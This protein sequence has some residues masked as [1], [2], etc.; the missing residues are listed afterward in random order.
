M[1]LSL[2][3]LLAIADKVDP[4]PQL[5]RQPD[6]TCLTVIGHG[7]E[8]GCYLTTSDGVLIVMDE[9][10]AYVA[11]VTDGSQLLSSG[12]LAHEAGCRDFSEKMAVSLQNY[13]AFV[14]TH[15][16]EVHAMREKRDAY[17][18]YFPHK[19]SPKVL[20]VLVEYQDS[21][22]H[23]D[24]SREI[25]D[26][27]LNADTLPLD[28]ADGTLA[29]NYSSVRQ[30]FREMSFGQFTPQF[31]VVG[32]VRL[33]NT[34]RY[35]GAGQND[36][37]T[38]LVNDAM[39]QVL[40]SIDVTEYD[41]DGDGYI[42]LTYFISASYSAAS[43]SADTDLYIWP[44]ITTVV[45][46]TGAGVKTKK[47]G[48]SCELNRKPASY[49]TPHVSGIGIFCHEFCHT[50][51]MPDL[52]STNSTARMLN[53]TFEYWDLMDGG[54][55]TAYGLYPKALSAVE[56]EQMEWMTI[57]ELSTPADIELK[58]LSD[59]DGMAY[60]I[61]PDPDDRN[62][63]FVLENIQK[64]AVDASALSHG[65]LVSS[66]NYT[67]QT[68]TPNNK[69]VKDTVNDTV[70]Y[71]SNSSYTIVPADSFIVMSYIV[72]QKIYDYDGGTVNHTVS[73]YQK[74]LQ[75]D[76]YPG[77]YGVTTLPTVCKDVYRNVTAGFY[78]FKTKSGYTG[79]PVT[80]IT[81]RDGV[82][83]LK[84]DGGVVDIVEKVEDGTVM[85]RSSV[86]FNPAGQ[87][88][89]DDYHGLVISQGH[90]YLQ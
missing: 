38:A 66:Y 18:S 29:E 59:P 86:R 90:K 25:F 27:Y 16:T 68:M 49:P 28:L 43:N 8:D 39:P 48:V 5:I 23:W 20:V 67:T 80:D 54:E 76:L 74:S 3:W 30:Y 13:R 46:D 21:I 79:K 2:S 63:Y 52:Y 24:N 31:D 82:V 45:Y 58:P 65:L 61:Y 15:D 14:K 72:G 9:G 42:D 77:Q 12:V 87:I 60:R 34:L 36:N 50:M 83:Y 89:G 53:Q 4:E 41:E 6:G 1:M 64:T 56:R 57:E 47:V 17:S 78:H 84:Y 7:D 51:G 37:I 69:Y 55:Y 11:Q 71:Y 85:Q 75:N 44:K 22:F 33:P 10:Q 35:Y 70:Y 32:P 73:T 88:V 62:V 19:G 81:E 26:A 40:D